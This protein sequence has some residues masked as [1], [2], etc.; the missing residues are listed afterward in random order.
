MYF[1]E[2]DHGTVYVVPLRTT[3]IGFLMEYFQGVEK[4]VFQDSLDGELIFTHIFVD[5]CRVCDDETRMT[6]S[7]SGRGGFHHGDDDDM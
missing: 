4:K 6:D 7:Q 5:G 1:G 3:V 2:G